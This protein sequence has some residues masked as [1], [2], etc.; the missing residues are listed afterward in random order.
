MLW[1]KDS[2]LHGALSQK[3]NL[4]TRFV[5]NPYL[6]FMVNSPPPRQE[7]M[8]ANF[9]T[10]HCFKKKYVLKYSCE[11]RIRTSTGHLAEHIRIDF[12]PIRI[13]SVYCV[14]PT[15]ET[16]GHVCQFQ[17]LTLFLVNSITFD[18]AN[19]WPI[20]S[21]SIIYLIKTTNK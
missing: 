6:S 21:Y 7:G 5:V 3:A 15:P 14:F 4:K 9:N 2:N 1:E 19:I 17:H 13:Y 16:G 12:Y 8:S 20:L 11:R 18:S 10:S